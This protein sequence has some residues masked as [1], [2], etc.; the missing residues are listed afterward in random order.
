MRTRVL[1]SFA[2]M[3]LLLS[4]AL[5]RAQADATTTMNVSGGSQGAS[6]TV[7]PGQSQFGM[8]VPLKP[9]AD[10]ILSV[11]ATDA[12]GRTSRVDGL[13]VAQIS[14]T[15]IVR[16]TVTAQRLTTAEVKQLVAEGVID[17]ADPANYNVSVFVVAL[18][19]GGQEVQVS[20]PVV[21]E[22]N[23]PIG[24]G[25]AIMI[26]CAQP[27]Q[28][29]TTTTRAIA[30]P[31][32]GGGNSNVQDM[33][34]VPFEVV[35]PA[36]EGLPPVSIPGVIVIEGRIKTLKEF[37]KVDL[38]LM[39][40]STL[41]TL[42]DL[43]ARIEIPQDAL[44]PVLPT[45]GAIGMPDV[46]AGGDASGQFIVRGDAKGTHTVRVHFGG[47][48]IAPFL[49]GP[50]AFSGKASTD[51]EV[52][53]PPQLDVKVSH[54]DFVVANR[55]YEL[56]VSIRNTD[57]VLDALYTSIA[58]DVGGDARLID[59]ST[60]EPLEGPDVRSVGDILRGQTVVQSYRVL[61]RVSGPIT[62]CVAAADANIQLSVQFIGRDVGC[63]I[64]TLPGSRLAADGKP[65]VTVVPAHNTLNVSID[66]AIV[67]LFSHRM[68]EA[69]ITTGYPGASF[70][71]LDTGGKALDGTL[72]FTELFGGTAAIFRPSSPLDVATTYSIVVN[73]SIFNLEGLSLASGIVA[74]FT[75]A[76]ASTPPDM[77]APVISL[78]LAPPLVAAAI[79]RGQTIEVVADSTDAS[80]V[81][82]V[83]LRLD[84]ALI[85]SKRPHSPVSFLVDTGTLD[86]GSMHRLV[87]QAFD[88]AGNVGAASL[89][90]QIAPDVTPPSA[91][92]A[93]APAVVR[94]AVLPINVEASDDGRVARVELFVDN[95]PDP[96]G[97][98]MAPPFRFALPTASLAVGQHLLRAVVTDGAGN[99]REVASPFD[100]LLSTTAP[101]VTLVGPLASRFRRGSPVSFLAVASDPHGVV[102]LTYV[103]DGEGPV[104][105]TGPSGATLQ[106]A[107]LTLGPHVVAIS[108]ING[109]GLMT[110]LSVPFE[111]YDTAA[112][113]MPPIP[114]NG[115]LVSLSPPIGGVVTVTGTAG[116]AGVSL[117]VS[118]TNL[119]TQ[120]S[121]IVRAA[122]SG[123]FVAHIDASGG[124]ALSLVVVDADGNQSSPVVFIVPMPAALTS[125]HVAPSSITLDRSHTSATLVVTGIFSDNTQRALTS[126][127]VTLSSSAPTIASVNNAGL[128]LPGQNGSATITVTP[129]GSAVTPVAVPV[130]VSFVNVTGLTATPNPV[131]IVGVGRSQ[132]I[133]VSAQYSDGTSGPFNGS[134]KFT[135][136]NGAV[137]GV[138]GTGLVT[139][140]AIGSTSVF[141]AAADLPTVAVL[142]VVEPLAP[143]AL[144]VSPNSVAF[145]ALGQSTSLVPTFRYSDDTVG[146]GPYPVTYKSLDPSVATVTGAGTI[147]AVGEGLASIVV[148]SLS[149]T[150]GVP[151]S[152]SLSTAEAPP[153][154]TSLGRPVAG[155]AD[156]LELRGRNFSATPAGNF[157]QVGSLHADVVSAASDR[158]VVIVPRGAPATSQVDVRVA[159]ATSSALDLA[160]Y[161][162]LARTVLSSV[163]FNASPALP[164]QIADLGTA[165]FYLY[166]GDQVTLAA[167]PNTINS[168]TWTSLVG[169]SFT[170]MLT[171]TVNGTDYV[172]SAS[173]QPIDIANRLP[174]VTEPTLVTIGMRVEPI[175]S[176]LAARAMAIV[177]GPPGT[178]ALAGQRF[179]TGDTLD[180][181][182]TLRFRVAAA[183]GTKFAATATSWNR[184]S[185]GG[186]C[187]DSAGGAMRD[188]ATTPNDNRFLTYTASGGEV[189]VTYSSTGVFADFA[190]PKTAVIALLQADASGNRLGTT[191]VAEAKILLAPLDSA[192]V[193]AQQPTLVADGA[194]R[195][196]VVDV[197]SVRDYYGNPVLEQTPVALTATSWN[198]RGDGS[199]CNGSVGG[200]ITGG[201]TAANDSR[202]QTSALSNGATQFTYSAKDIALGGGVTR[203]A[204][205]AL[206]AATSNNNR[207]GVRPFS[208]GRVLLSSITAG[209]AIT[210]ATPNVLTASTA[211]SRSVITLTGLT[212][213]D[214]RPVPDGSRIAVTAV[215][216]TRL[217]DGG[218]CN[219]SFGGTIVGGD[220]VPN[221]S[222]FRSFVVQ[223]GQ[224][225]FTYSNV[226][227]VLD[228]GT[229]AT[230]VIAIL[231]AKSTGDLITS[232]PFAEARVTQAGVTSA[233]IVATPAS[234]LA[235]GVRRPVAIAVTNIRD[236]AGNLVPDGT[237]VALTA[238]NW[239]RRSDGGCCND[240]VGG[241]LLD[242]VVAP[243]DNRFKVFTV[244]DGRVD[245][246]YSA[247]TIS[248]LDVT[249]IRSGVIAATVANASNNSRMT[250][251]PFGEGT[252][253]VSSI[254][255]ATANA[256]PVSLLADRQ[257]RTST[258]TISG[259]TD[260][261]GLPVANGTK[262][263]IT[264][265]DWNRLSDGG[266][267]NGSAGGTMLGG[268][269]TPNDNRFRSYT[270]VDRTVTATYSDID[271]FVDT[272]STAA[273]ILSIL[274]ASVDGSRVGTRPFAVAQVTLAGFDSATVLAPATIIADGST[275][276]TL[277]NI[278]DAAGNLVPDGTRIAVTAANW[279]N[280]DGSCCNNS[281]GGTIAGGSATPN[282]SR[283][284]TLT[285]AGGEVSFTLTAP[286]TSGVTSVLSA[287]PAD[288]DGNRTSIKPFAA[289]AIR[290]Q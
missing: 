37:F 208:E 106:T 124:H 94:G 44:T 120:A 230:S 181:Q 71:V 197:N 206:L 74:R 276:V 6:Q 243:N 163:P 288:G 105:G 177:A 204:W 10:N 196:I 38:K 182:L 247:E 242:G 143:T 193:I 257:A 117:L 175:G 36:I 133:A 102:S 23:Q 61:P 96:A 179:L 166:P 62:S 264:A 92:I 156:T 211:D 236:A 262:V 84:N 87:A 252:V 155:D 174:L 39:N 281:A 32:G 154:L 215:N 68:I 109:S 224:A 266:C 73:P 225:T 56:T 18:V 45:S 234:T 270:V 11:L 192:S 137:A 186:C 203:D 202:F 171:L 233:S 88:A 289:F 57:D 190:A 93:H 268:D 258:V 256:S 241:A 167:D 284:R 180:H 25:E 122:A 67:A 172:I 21:R 139:A 17:V 126:S 209:H 221:D 151:V 223:S 164:N 7:P 72:T 14:L 86:A 269:P 170:G 150:V 148:Q 217:D 226:G 76:A 12:T 100:V 228:R 81:V 50:I 104:F 282:D 253:A 283:F 79:P 240:S 48:L 254:A 90:V 127:D 26:G 267:C 16:A 201:S 85:D 149:F 64:G 199:C 121:A 9:N 249:T 250:T 60:G 173:S 271:R 125:V 69:T 3:L 101:T 279:N 277:T 65:T 114:V 138:D 115:G 41:F 251:T 35:P 238:N 220:P 246:T 54:P 116:A 51:L 5:A 29:L 141:V 99:T 42:T 129:I 261:Q 213:A 255:T 219:G 33:A 275:S 210:T 111:L 189:A 75:T 198:R 214:G 118:V 43:T 178:G 280:R 232:Q 265:V 273:A 248:P 145:I 30:V 158:L 263:A 216:W 229:T 140:A 200:I 47:N 162:R 195:P 20:V 66:P 98:G 188:G 70:N 77:I 13:S 27:G 95:R 227:L 46:A 218:C 183:D 134:V 169:P 58:I 34:I 130:T 191:P 2:G 286:A 142:V 235:D 194:D 89:D 52:K 113:T 78:A 135:T 49:P 184:V 8:L 132:R 212:D 244:V 80:G 159:G 205:L 28:P 239:N 152:V 131:T 144:I 53:G 165:S 19:V 160:I 245:A 274:P 108:A 24:E 110:T 278:R 237:R 83:D 59:P 107:D 176:Q 128:V 119:I 157:V 1:A 40:V 136:G 146:S 103:L 22:I 82:R 4:P 260:A 15:D 63:A 147:T 161:P 222:R 55:P 91:S 185:D 231:P 123:S 290:T 272:G 287:V 112:G 285:V 31:C 207:G 259:L 187:N 97:S 168:S 153:V